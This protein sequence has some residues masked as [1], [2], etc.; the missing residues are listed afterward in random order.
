MDLH[1]HWRVC[2]HHFIPNAT[3]CTS[4]KFLAQYFFH[5]YK[6]KHKHTPIVGYHNKT[7][8]HTNPNRHLTV[9]VAPIPWDTTGRQPCAFL[10]NIAKWLGFQTRSNH[11][12]PQRESNQ[13][14]FFAKRLPICVLAWGWTQN[15]IL[16]QYCLASKTNRRRV[17]VVTTNHHELKVA[18]LLK[19]L[20]VVQKKR[21]RKHN[22]EEAK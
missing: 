2:F 17:L 11:F 6:H 10:A 13:M 22:N 9:R 21:K 15:W 19:F 8:K 4:K 20:S 18:L 1:V 7:T 14:D 3:F 12:P 5:G 16:L